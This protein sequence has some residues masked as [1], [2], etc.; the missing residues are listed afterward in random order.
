L[1]EQDLPES[2]MRSITVGAAPEQIPVGLTMEQ[3]EKLAIIKALDQTRG[4]RTHAAGKLGISVRT[5][6]R[7]LRQ[8]DVDKQASATSGDLAT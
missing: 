1:V 4:N 3:L 2:I 5:L 8:Y 6:Q 7:K